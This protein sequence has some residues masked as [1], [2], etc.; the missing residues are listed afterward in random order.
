MA[1]T[2]SLTRAV[3]AFGARLRRGSNLQQQGG[4]FEYGL[5]GLFLFAGRITILAQDTFYDRAHYRAVLP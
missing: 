5:G 1:H 4:L 2:M 3:A